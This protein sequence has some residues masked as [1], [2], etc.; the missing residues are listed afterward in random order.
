MDSVINDAL[1]NRLDY[2]RDAEFLRKQRDQGTFE[3]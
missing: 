3:A 1:R 2:L